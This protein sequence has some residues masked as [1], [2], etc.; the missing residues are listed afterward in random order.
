MDREKTKE[1][2]G[3]RLR[4]ARED[5]AYSQS[6][7]AREMDIDPATL[8]NYE[9]GVNLPGG[10]FLIRLRKTHGVDLNWLLTGRR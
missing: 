8:W 9:M 1:Q 10:T 3:K 7:Y 6:D 2:V 5:A 4:K